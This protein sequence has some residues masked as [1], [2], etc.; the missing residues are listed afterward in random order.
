MT[1]EEPG[2]VG[3]A[4]AP[5]PKRVLVAVFLLIA[6]VLASFLGTWLLVGQ[7]QRAA[8]GAVTWGV[9]LTGVDVW[10]RDVMPDFL[11]PEDNAVAGVAHEA[12]G[13]YA[14]GWLRGVLAPA[15]FVLVSPFIVVYVAAI[16][17]LWFRVPGTRIASAVLAGLGVL[18]ALTLL[19]LG[20]PAYLPA[21]ALSVVAVILLAT[22]PVTLWYRDRGRR[23]RGSIPQAG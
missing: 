16:L 7:A 22:R 6:A 10:L 13:W 12:A 2:R 14:R 19:V 11:L 18:C 4:P 15:A 21:A 9:G 17:C 1:P 8:T 5:R 20:S 23:Y 3:A